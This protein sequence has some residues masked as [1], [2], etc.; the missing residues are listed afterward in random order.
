MPLRKS[1]EKGGPRPGFWR[2]HFGGSGA[3]GSQQAVHSQVSP[4]RI[5]SAPNPTGIVTL[6]TLP[7]FLQ[8]Q[9]G[10]QPIFSSPVQRNDLRPLTP[11]PHH[12]GLYDTYASNRPQVTGSYGRFNTATQV[13]RPPMASQQ[14]LSRQNL[15]PGNMRYLQLPDRPPN[16]AFHSVSYLPD[17]TSAR[18]Y[19]SPGHQASTQSQVYPSSS[20]PTHANMAQYQGQNAYQYTNPHVPPRE[21][22][23]SGFQYQSAIPPVSIPDSN[24]WRRMSME[25]PIATLVSVRNMGPPSPASSHTSSSSDTL[26]RPPSKGVHM[27]ASTRI[28]TTASSD[29][30]EDLV[31]ADN[32]NGDDQS[33]PGESL[34]T[35]DEELLQINHNDHCASIS[36]P[37]AWYIQDPETFPK[38]DPRN[39]CA[40]C[41]H[42]NIKHLYTQQATDTCP[43][44][45]E[46]IRL[47]TLVEFV[48]KFRA[49]GL[50]HFFMRLIA[51][52]VTTKR[53][54]HG[55]S[56][57]DIAAEFFGKY[58]TF[59]SNQDT[60]YYMY[61]NQFKSTYN[62]PA[63]YLCRGAPPSP[64]ST[65]LIR[66]DYLLGFREVHTCCRAPNTGRH[67]TSRDEIDIEW[68]KEQLEL[69]DERSV[70]APT[71]GNL[72]VQIR[73]IDVHRMCIVDL[74][75]G[76]V[77]VTLSYV[78]GEAKQ[79]R[80]IWETESLLRRE[81]GLTAFWDRIPKTI[82][83]AITLT[84]KIGLDYL[85]IDAL[86]IIQ[87]DPDDQMRLIKQMGSIYQNSTLTIM[88]QCG[89]DAA[90]GL[91]G[92]EPGTRDVSQMLGHAGKSV[93]CNMLPDYETM[94]SVW[95]SRAWTMQ[96]NVLS[97]RKLVITDQACT[98]W[99][100]HT[101]S[102]EDTYCRHR[103]WPVGER[104]RGM[105]FF[106]GEHSSIIPTV[107]RQSNFDTYA[108]MVSDYSQRKMKY[109]QDAE[110][111][112]LGV[113]DVIEGSFQGKFVYG[114]PD[115]EIDSALLWYPS[116]ASRRRVNN[117]TGLP[118]FPSWSWLGWEGHAC[119]PWATERTLPLTTMGCPLR[120]R[121]AHSSGER[122]EFET[123]QNRPEAH[124]LYEWQRCED[125]LWCWRD[126]GSFSPD[127]R[128][129]NPVTYRRTGAFVNLRTHPHRLQFRTL[130]ALF[131]LS[132]RP[133]PRTEKY[134][135]DHDIHLMH[136]LD[137]RGFCVG[138]V[139]IPS[140]EQFTISQES[141]FGDQNALY[142]FI[143]LSRASIGSDP[144]IGLEKLQDPWV[145]STDGERELSKNRVLSLD[146]G[147]T[148]FLHSLGMFD[149]R[150]YDKAVPYCLF[151]VMMIEWD[152]AHE[153]A[154]R[155]SIGRIHVDAFLEADPCMKSICLE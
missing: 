1:K 13:S 122:R 68:I 151:N 36:A 17:T 6:Q 22:F 8:Q 3:E 85:W 76:E 150:L 118:L 81:R 67:I 92:V 61:P 148:S 80:L 77:Y 33:D 111:A 138:A 31:V 37:P 149:E 46:F 26:F 70:G 114:L 38:G 42:I 98:F 89:E 60:E 44:P 43:K 14:Y 7:G 50:C 133:I 55:A 74:E 69:C 52:E 86:C 4:R 20:P 72:N 65:A 71:S 94:P 73:V 136:V 134:N 137:A 2:R 154:Q 51:F 35:I 79:V 115:A 117:R 91:P 40:T 145:L 104:F 88:A 18:D 87:D 116:G 93:V 130:S 131:R 15:A 123:I 110:N 82:R 143:A 5:D 101:L 53:L 126:T 78:W 27:S 144:R 54:G 153:V 16:P 28:I 10:S 48:A 57:N 102:G 152:E 58:L 128:L 64:E 47:G 120:W 62:V 146:S 109:Q 103:Y 25:T 135:V 9:N 147:D 45:E 129:W 100:V 66:P 96:E 83:D 56:I 34:F 41:R 63:V 23:Q 99:C 29:S 24:R 39:L 124:E 49:C 125:D 139:F 32:Y 105:L 11:Q 108:F 113:L 84:R 119:Y 112:M 107:K 90:Y 21:P 155:I 121:D 140:P 106:K 75:D 95:E 30:N 59:P 19:P 142:E 12:Q 132:A 127:S 97:Q 141:A